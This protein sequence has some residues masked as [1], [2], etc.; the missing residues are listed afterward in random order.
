MPTLIKAAEAWIPDESGT[1]LSL[2]SACYGPGKPFE[3]ISRSMTFKYGEGLAGRAWKAGKPLIINDIAHSWFTRKDFLTDTGIES[4]LAIPIFS[5]EFLQGVMT[6]YLGP[7]LIS[8]RAAGAVEVW[9]NNETNRNNELRLEEGYYGELSRFEWVSRKLTM[10]KDFGLPGSAWAEE[11]PVLIEDI[12]TSNS[13]LRQQAAAESG[14]K[15]GIAMP[16]CRDLDQVD[17]VTVLSSTDTPIAKQFEVWLPD[18]NRETLVFYKGYIGELDQDQLQ[19]LYASQ[20]YEK[21]E[22]VL[23]EAWLSGRPRVIKH[24]SH[25]EILLPVTFHGKLSAVVIF[26]I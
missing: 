22:G 8:G 19:L 6:L 26:K 18:S 1:E 5:G 24:I 13:F 21:G 7:S 2:G 15:L 14:M 3:T 9:V 10:M 16:Y 17:I 23:G 12:S 11:I 4:A 25:S 20:T